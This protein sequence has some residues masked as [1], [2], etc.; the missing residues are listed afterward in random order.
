MNSFMR[1]LVKFEIYHQ[2]MEILLKFLKNLKTNL[3]NNS[4]FAST[5]ELNHI[6]LV[7]FNNKN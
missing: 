2:I 7:Y 3:T 6:K 4:S 1:E 5:I